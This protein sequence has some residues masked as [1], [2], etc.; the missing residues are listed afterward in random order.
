MRMVAILVPAMRRCRAEDKHHSS[1][2]HMDAWMHGLR[3][4]IDAYNV[5]SLIAKDGDACSKATY[6]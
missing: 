6:Q 2:S 5:W 3:G 4:C 1:S